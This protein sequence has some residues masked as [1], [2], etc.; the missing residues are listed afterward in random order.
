MHYLELNGIGSHDAVNSIE[1]NSAI[2]YAI[3]DD[4]GIFPD[5]TSSEKP[6]RCKV[7]N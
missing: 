4:N 7:S 6:E 3:A 1:F 2:A 5:M